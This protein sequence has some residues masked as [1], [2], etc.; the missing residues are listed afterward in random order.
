MKSNST[1]NVC[2]ILDYL[3]NSNVCICDYAE[4]VRLYVCS[5]KEGLL[6]LYL[7]FFAKGATE[8]NPLQDDCFGSSGVEIGSSCAMRWVYHSNGGEKK[9][10]R[11]LPRLRTSPCHLCPCKELH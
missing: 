1:I 10:N 3:C 7:V 11:K 8:T 2:H 5:L 4:S 6:Q 9:K